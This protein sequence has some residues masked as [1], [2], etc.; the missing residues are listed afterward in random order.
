MMICYVLGTENT[1]GIKKMVRKM[2]S[3]TEAISP[4]RLQFSTYFLWGW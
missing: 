1:L 2:F 3:K 4:M